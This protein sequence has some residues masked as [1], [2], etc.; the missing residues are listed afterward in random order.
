MRQQLH[1]NINT[2]LKAAELIEVFHLIETC[3]FRI[4][5]IELGVYTYPF[6][7]LYE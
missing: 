2:M 7:D 1:A 3:S 4:V 6:S 5:L